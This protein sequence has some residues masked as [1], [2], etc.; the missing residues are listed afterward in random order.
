VHA[1]NDRF[2]LV[3]FVGF[4]VFLG[5]AGVLMLVGLKGREQY[6]RREIG[7]N[8]LRRTLL[9]ATVLVLV[10]MAVAGLTEC[11]SFRR[12]VPI[13]SR[14][15]CQTKADNSAIGG[16]VSL[17]SSIQP[18]QRLPLGRRWSTLRLV[19]NRL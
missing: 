8:P 7:F 3:A 10:A 13:G 16:P 5:F 1:S 17:M 4:F 9:A 12:F 2:L 11:G 18:D 6:L 14:G 19:L 15:C